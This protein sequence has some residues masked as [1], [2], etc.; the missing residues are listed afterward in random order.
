MG[1]KETARKRAASK[2]DAATRREA[3]DRR[4][5]TLRES[6]TTQT[7][8]LSIKGGWEVSVDPR[9]IRENRV[10]YVDT[11]GHDVGWVQ[12]KD[13]GMET[14]FLAGRSLRNHSRMASRD[15]TPGTIATPPATEAIRGNLAA[16]KRDVQTS[17]NLVHVKARKPR[18]VVRTKPDGRTAA[19]MAAGV[20]GE[21]SATL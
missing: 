12:P 14:R 2:A 13:A 16:R 15:S 10:V 20:P 6:R 5:E 8:N 19:S 7:R 4:L 3:T 9:D 1:A 18:P 21:I 17:P 11:H